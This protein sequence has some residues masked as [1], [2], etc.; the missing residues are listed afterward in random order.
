MTLIVAGNSEFV[1]QYLFIY[2]FI[3]LF[4]LLT[5]FINSL[6]TAQ[7]FVT[8]SRDQ[9]YVCTFDNSVMDTLVFHS[10]MEPKFTWPTPVVH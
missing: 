8:T 9:P 2:L 3:Y 6:I 4:Y 10:V 5:L 1:F 7:L